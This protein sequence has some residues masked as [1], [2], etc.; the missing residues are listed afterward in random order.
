MSPC[1]EKQRNNALYSTSKQHRILGGKASKKGSYKGVE[2]EQTGG[3]KKDRGYHKLSLTETAMFR[4]KQLLSPKL[5][6]RNYNDQVGEALAN[7]K[8][9]NKVI[10]SG[11]PVHHR[12]N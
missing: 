1:T 11:I 8:A 9:M 5:T 12:I 6:L 4:Y 7:V 10:R 2:R 3:M